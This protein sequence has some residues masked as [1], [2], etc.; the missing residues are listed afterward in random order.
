MKSSK[1]LI[2]AVLGSGLIAAPALAQVTPSIKGQFMTEQSSSDWL[3]SK[4]VGLN[5]YDPQKNKIGAIQQLLIDRN[6]VVEGVVIGVGG[7]LG[8]DKK[9]V[10]LP[11]KSL[12]FVAQKPGD[13][14]TTTGSNTS[15]AAADPAKGYP[16]HAVVNTTKDELKKAPDF[17]YAS[18]NKK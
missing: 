18:E 10:A 2:C 4:L 5:I 1:I 17:H 15:T 6:G 9:E 13:S 7:F 11:F 3:G 14:S 16:D 8:V 12:Q